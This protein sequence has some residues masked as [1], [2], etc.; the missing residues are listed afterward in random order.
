[1]AK[2]AS[3]N[4]LHIYSSYSGK[5]LLSSDVLFNTFPRKELGVKGD[6]LCHLNLINFCGAVQALEIDFHPICWQPQN[7]LIGGGGTSQV[8][9]SLLSLELGLAFKA[10]DVGDTS[11]ARTDDDEKHIF[12]LLLADIQHMGRKS[13]LN[14]PYIQ[15]VDGVSWSLNKRNRVAD[16]VLMFEKAPYGDMYHFMTGGKGKSFDIS[17]RLRMCRD[18]AIGLETLHNC[19]KFLNAL[20]YGL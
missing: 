7:G 2:D 11:R 20:R 19:S 14:S 18:V 1:M 3:Q 8:N 12:S 6:F 16:P 9:Q 17:D 5:N 10:I 13:I 4:A 15:R